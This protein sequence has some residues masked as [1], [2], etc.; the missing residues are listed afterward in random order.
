MDAINIALL[1]SI[2]C[3]FAI[4]FSI[5]LYRDTNSCHLQKQQQQQQQHSSPNLLLVDVSQASID[6]IVSQVVSGV[7]NDQDSIES[8]L[9]Q[10]IYLQMQAASNV[11]SM[12]QVIQLVLNGI[13]GQC[14]LNSYTGYNG[15]NSSSNP[16]A[17][18]YC[19]LTRS[20]LY[21]I[22]DFP[23]A[24]LLHTNYFS[25]FVLACAQSASIY[26]QVVGCRNC[27]SNNILTY[28]AFTVGP[29]CTGESPTP[30]PT[31]LWIY[32]IDP[33]SNVISCLVTPS[34]PTRP[35]CLFLNQN[36]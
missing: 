15:L 25:Q 9:N 11:P 27:K 33:T 3:F 17:L 26:P 35:S 20:N 7:D 31:A 32:G 24:N 2:M 18:F 13:G 16:D 5:A 14:S 6:A 4:V 8:L 12:G 21:I 22:D 29:Y 19:N 34:Q 10:S 1:S 28:G 30:S 36:E 23:N